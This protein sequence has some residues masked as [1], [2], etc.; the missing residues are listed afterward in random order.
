V[1][2][3]TTPDGQSALSLIGTEA[4]RFEYSQ[5]GSIAA[6][7]NSNFVPAGER[8]WLTPRAGH[9]FSLRIA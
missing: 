1:L 2:S 5:A 3:G 4:F 8:L 7:G 6:V 9:K